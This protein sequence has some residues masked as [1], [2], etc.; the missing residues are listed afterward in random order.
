MTTP[1]ERSTVTLRVVSPCEHGI[2]H[3]I[4]EL[5]DGAVFSTPECK[6][7]RG[8]PRTHV[9]DAASYPKQVKRR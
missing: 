9:A 6:D 4:A 5:I 3:S 1:N 8:V 2:E 7:S